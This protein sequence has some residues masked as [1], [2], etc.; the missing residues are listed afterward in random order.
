M[1]FRSMQKATIDFKLIKLE[2]N[3]YHPVCIVTINHKEA[4][5]VIDTSASHTVLDIKQASRFLPEK[6]IKHSEVKSS[7]LGTNEMMSA[8]A[9]LDY[10]IMGD[11]VLRRRKIII[12]DLTHIN[13]AYAAMQ[14][15]LIDGVIGC[16]ILKKYKANISFSTKKLVIAI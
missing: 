11:L 12:L 8:F 15:P 6:K 9:T 1:Y 10:F 16:D 3:G 5:M 7:G 2:R 4:L 13:L 14:L